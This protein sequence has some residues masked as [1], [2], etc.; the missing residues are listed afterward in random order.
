MAAINR[1]KLAAKEN[2]ARAVA[3]EIKGIQAEIK[4]SFNNAGT[5]A[6]LSDR[7]CKAEQKLALITAKSEQI[8]AEK[9]DQ[10]DLETALAMFDPLWDSMPPAERG[11]V[12]ALL[13]ERIG[14]DGKQGTLSIT[15]HAC[16]IRTLINNKES[17]K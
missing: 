15:F 6:D 5:L 8:R 2:E 12:V 13:L 9:L 17:A 1:D 7:L 14:Y 16:G 10:A 11:R 4:Q 3:L